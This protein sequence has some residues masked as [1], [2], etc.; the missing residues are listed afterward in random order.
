MFQED[1]HPRAA[2]GGPTGGQFAAASSGKSSGPLGSKTSITRYKSAGGGG[3]GGK[4]GGKGGKGGK[5]RGKGAMRFDPKTGR[6]TGY[7]QK[8]GDPRVHSLQSM[9]TKLGFKDADGKPL[10]NDGKLGPKT[11]AAIK[12]AQRKYG[13]PANGVVTPALISKLKGGKPGGRR[14]KLIGRPKALR[15][16]K[17]APPPKG[18]TA[19]QKAADAR[20]AK[21]RAGPSGDSDPGAA[22]RSQTRKALMFRGNRS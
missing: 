12:A 4:G 21:F 22:E 5:A 14:G 15:S 13:L 2:A 9:L 19:Q 7:D 3:G 18:P 11:T 16:P 17:A 6:G 20:R 10:K 1:Q 8:N